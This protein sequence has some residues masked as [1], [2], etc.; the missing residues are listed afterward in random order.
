MEVNMIE[1]GGLVATK[2][3]LEIMSV[4]LREGHSS[5]FVT[6]MKREIQV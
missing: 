6:E 4:G 2:L 3:E 5:S 1:S